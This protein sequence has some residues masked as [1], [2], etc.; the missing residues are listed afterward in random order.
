M[1]VRSLRRQVVAFLFEART[2]HFRGLPV[3]VLFLT[4][5]LLWLSLS[6]LYTLGPR[7]LSLGKRPPPAGAMDRTQPITGSAARFPCASF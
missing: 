4:P 3:V 2:L 1:C 6:S 7:L 5:I